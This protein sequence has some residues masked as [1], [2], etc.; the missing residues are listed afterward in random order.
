LGATC[1]A[2]AELRALSRADPRKPVFALKV[3]L[4]LVLISLIGFLREP[5]E[6]VDHTMW[7][8]LTAVLVFE[9]SIGTHRIGASNT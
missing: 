5:R 9:F 7:A 4:A 6:I 1:A 8:I 2:A 3:S